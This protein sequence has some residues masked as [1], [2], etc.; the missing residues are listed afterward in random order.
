MIAQLVEREERLATWRDAISRDA[1]G[2]RR[3]MR[4]LVA[5]VQADLLSVDGNIADDEKACQ[6]G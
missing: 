2:C 1:P 6:I 4:R 3:D 5:R